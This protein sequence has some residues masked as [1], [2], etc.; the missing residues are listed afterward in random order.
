MITS[1]V[2]YE[3]KSGLLLGEREKSERGGSIWEKVMRGR[4]WRNF[5][6]CDRNICHLCL[7]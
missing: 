5:V 6:L 1:L 7:S 2:G 3:E 4:R